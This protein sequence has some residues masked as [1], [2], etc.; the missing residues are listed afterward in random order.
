MVVSELLRLKHL[1]DENRRL[2]QLYAE[3]S[4]EH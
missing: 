1:E 4:L 2:K 3:L